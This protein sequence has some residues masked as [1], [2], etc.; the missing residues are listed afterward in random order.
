MK[1]STPLLSLGVLLLVCGA[2]ITTRAQEGLES[3]PMRDARDFRGT[4]S[5]GTHQEAEVDNKSFK[6]AA[7]NLREV[8][9]RENS[10]RDSVYH[11]SP[12]VPRKAEK[13]KVDD[14]LQFNFLY[15]IIQR[16]KFSDIIE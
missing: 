10:S 6:P 15:Y 2:A 11:T 1:Q 4:E 12:A 14:V 3:L 9:V 13:Q 5:N 16:F 7:G 8:M